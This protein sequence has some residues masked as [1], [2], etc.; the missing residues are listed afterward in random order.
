MPA[1]VAHTRAS[2][3]SRQQTSGRRSTRQGR[4]ERGSHRWQRWRRG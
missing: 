4:G 1:L 3:R 2:C